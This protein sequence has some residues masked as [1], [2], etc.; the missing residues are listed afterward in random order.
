MF[1]FVHDMLHHNL[2]IDTIY[3]LTDSLISSTDEHSAAKLGYRVA[4]RACGLHRVNKALSYSEGWRPLSPFV[5]ALY[6][7]HFLLGEFILEYNFH[8]NQGIQ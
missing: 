4:W 1:E 3:Y 7:L 8:A 2:F 6:M 5:T